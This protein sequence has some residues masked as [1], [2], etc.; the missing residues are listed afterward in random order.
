M[1]CGTKQEAPQYN[2]DA[3]C[4][5]SL[6]SRLRSQQGTALQMSGKKKK[7][8]NLNFWVRTSSVGVGVFHVKGWGPKSSVCPSKPGKPSFWAG[9]PRIFAGISRGCLKSSRIK[10]C[11]QVVAPKI[12]GVLRYKL[13]VPLVTK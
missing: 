11:V 13:L 12:G 8:A 1:H 2:L 7:S 4:R 5:V 6:S 3:H 10:I 9:Y